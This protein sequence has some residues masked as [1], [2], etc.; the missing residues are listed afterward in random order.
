[1]LCNMGRK[2]DDK[3]GT[4]AKFATYRN[5]PPHHPAEFPGYGQAEARSA[6][7]SGGRIIRLGKSLENLG[8]LVF[9]HADSG[10]GHAERYPVLAI[11]QPIQG[12]R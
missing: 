8:Y 6:I 10:I 11:F 9:S 12:N 4:H 3:G 7:F 2:L 5:I 1:M